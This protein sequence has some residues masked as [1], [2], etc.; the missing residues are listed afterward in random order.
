MQQ[1]HDDIQDRDLLRQLRQQMAEL[2][3]QF[4]Q[5]VLPRYESGWFAVQSHSSNEIVLA[6]NLNRVP[7]IITILFCADNPDVCPAHRPIINMSAMGWYH[8]GSPHQSALHSASIEVST[9][10]LRIGLWH[11]GFVGRYWSSRTDWV[12]ERQGFYKITA[13]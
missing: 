1:A 2:R 5:S 9:T 12:S 13:Q 4:A 7:T 6:H 3:A 8:N 11:G 10:H